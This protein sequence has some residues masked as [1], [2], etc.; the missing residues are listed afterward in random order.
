MDPIGSSEEDRDTSARGEEEEKNNREENERKNIDDRFLV[1]GVEVF[2]IYQSCLS[3]G[4]AMSIK[5]KYEILD[6]Y[7]IKSLLLMTI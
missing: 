4:D 5:D 1:D 3:V 7:V 2:R 6:E